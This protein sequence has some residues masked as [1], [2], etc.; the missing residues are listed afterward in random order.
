MPAERFSFDFTTKIDVYSLGVTMFKIFFDGHI[1]GDIKNINKNNFMK[2]LRENS[3]KI[4][5]TP[6]KLFIYGVPEIIGALAK[7]S[8]GCVSIDPQERPTLF[9][10]TSILVFAKFY[11]HSLI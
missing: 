10:I 2:C 3:L 9:Y 5:M 4:L 8:L 7:L 1:W 6:E 11:L